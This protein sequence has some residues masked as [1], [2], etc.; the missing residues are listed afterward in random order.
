MRSNSFLSA[1]QPISKAH[2]NTT[3]ANPAPTKAPWALTPFGTA[4]PVAAVL[5]ALATL[6]APEAKVLARLVA[7]DAASL[8]AVENAPPAPDV[9]VYAIPEP[10]DPALL[11]TTV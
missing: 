3:R 2:S 6:D 8:V 7:T 10:T 9:I 1:L 5:A 4:A 11:V